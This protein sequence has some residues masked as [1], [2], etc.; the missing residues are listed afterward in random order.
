MTT[1]RL[2]AIVPTRM[3]KQETIYSSVL[4]IVCKTG[5]LAETNFT[6]QAGKGSVMNWTPAYIQAVATL[7]S[8]YANFSNSTEGTTTWN[9]ISGM[10]RT[11]RDHWS[12]SMPTSMNWK[13]D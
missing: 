6:R 13:V 7:S 5:N 4:V 12:L 2:L 10:T 1:T 11:L 9:T 8:Q 3:I